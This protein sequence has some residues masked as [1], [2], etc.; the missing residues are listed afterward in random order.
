MAYNRVYNDSTKEVL[1]ETREG[2]GDALDWMMARAKGDYLAWYGEEN[3]VTEE[4][5]EDGEITGWWSV[6]D[7]FD[8]NPG[9]WEL[10]DGTVVKRKEE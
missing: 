5:Q 7:I 9:G 2:L 8:C 4:V 1:Y 3:I 10:P 6:G